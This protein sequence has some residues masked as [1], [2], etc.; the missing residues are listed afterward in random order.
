[1]STP[2]DT[3]KDSFLNDQREKP[4]SSYDKTSKCS[5]N[6]EQP[7]DIISYHEAH[8]FRLPSEEI[9]RGTFV[10][11]IQN[12]VLRDLRY[13]C[14]FND[15]DILPPSTEHTGYNLVLAL[16]DSHTIFERELA[17]K[18]EEDVVKMIHEELPVTKKSLRWFY[19]IC[20]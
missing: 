15:I 17:D 10:A 12:S 16:Y 11:S 7:H 19:P 3:S 8:Q 1:M 6:P 9:S 18:E 13:R 20:Q 2:S 5:Q 4:R 14:R